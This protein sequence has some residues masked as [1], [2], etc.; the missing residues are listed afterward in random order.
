M[1]RHFSRHQP[2]L[3]RS[4]LPATWSLVAAL[5]F[6][7]CSGDEPAEAV[8]RNVLVS[9]SVAV[10]SEGDVR[11]VVTATGTFASR[12]EIPLS[13]KIGGVVSRVLVDEGGTVERGQL[14]ASLDL[15]EINA[16]LDKAQ[17]G[18]DKALRD[19]QRLQR[20][21]ADSVAT[22]A[23]LQDATSARDAARADLIT[24]RVNRE[25]A[26]ITAPENGV[27][28]KRVVTPG[29]NIASGTP[30]LLIGGSR[31]GR[32][33]RVGL[34]DRDALRVA[35]GDSATV[36]FDAVPGERFA[37]RVIL[38]GRSADPRTGTYAVEVSL[39][40]ADALPS[41]L[42]GQLVIVTRGGRS[43]VMVPVDALLEADRDSA[44][45]YTLPDSGVL[46]ATPHRVRI[47]QLHGDRA[48]VE[49]L[50]QDA[51]VI[52]RGAAYVVPGAP[53]RIGSLGAT[54]APVRGGRAG[55]A[56]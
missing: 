15:R 20:L 46:I 5:L 31:R 12:D 35:L 25:Y 39:R 8:S 10:V 34:P 29:S 2:T 26:I 40:Q 7:G 6:A 53:V 13:F 44:T 17:V 52:T 51:R 11:Q 56:P 42:V 49:G 32:V 43:G 21:A 55:I 33:L 9:V 54:N 28:L 47:A 16:L 41:G 1:L 45:V 23:Q 3:P 19:F 37:G 24:A 27:V 4:E 30:A 18:Y 48:A 50:P 14:L 22:L 38:I 36:R